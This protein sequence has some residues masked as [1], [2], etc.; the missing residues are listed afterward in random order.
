M[1]TNQLYLEAGEI[2]TVTSDGNAVGTVL[3]LSNLP[4]GGNALEATAIAAGATTVFG[5]YRI[6]TRWQIDSNGGVLSGTTGPDTRISPTE[7]SLLDGLTK[8]TA[9]INALVVGV[10]GGYKLARSAAPVP[11]D[12]SNPT[13]VAHGLTTCLAAFVSLA[14]TAAPGLSTSTLSVAINGDNLDVYGWKPT[15]AG[16]TTLVAS[17]GTE[18]FNW[19]AIGA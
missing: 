18:T 17:T 5:P 2:L 16:D 7:A 3:R 15:G 13:S 9:Q 12:G 11:L 14:G 10:A 1:T 8:T 4:G 6:V 19:A